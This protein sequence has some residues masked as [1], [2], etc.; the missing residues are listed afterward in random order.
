MN[1]RFNRSVPYMI[2]EG[3]IVSECVAFY[4]GFDTIIG[5]VVLTDTGSYKRVWVL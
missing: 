2:N 4:A 5:Y 3:C 1:V